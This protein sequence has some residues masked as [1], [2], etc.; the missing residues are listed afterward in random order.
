MRDEKAIEAAAQKWADAADA[1]H[2]AAISW[3]TSAMQH[4]KLSRKEVLRLTDRMVV[5]SLSFGA[6]R[7]HYKEVSGE[8]SAPDHV[9]V[10]REG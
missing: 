1:L 7:A 8:G 10:Q 5:T 9:I 3:Y 4:G 6:A 2:E